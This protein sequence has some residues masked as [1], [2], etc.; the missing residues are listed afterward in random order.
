VARGAGGA[1]DGER[2]LLTYEG[3]VTHLTDRGRALLDHIDVRT[4]VGDP[5]RIRRGL[6][7]GRPGENA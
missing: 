5:D 7:D 1:P 3:H 2:H 4:F 6:A